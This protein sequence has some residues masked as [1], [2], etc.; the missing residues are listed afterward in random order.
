MSKQS[1]H[2]S[3]EPSALSVSMLVRNLQGQFQHEERKP[4]DLRA[5]L[6][7]DP[8]AN[9][10]AGVASGARRRRGNQGGGKTNAKGIAR[11]GPPRRRRTGLDANFSRA[12]PSTVLGASRPED[13]RMAP[14]PSRPA[15]M[16]ELPPNTAAGCLDRAAADLL[17]AD[18]SIDPHERKQLHQDAK[19]WSRRAEML[20]RVAKSISKRAAL[21]EGSR[22]Y[23][24]D[25]ARHR[26]E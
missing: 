15:T 26:S 17:E 3:D 18:A 19:W 12:R 5:S 4:Q 2:F 10:T 16:T 6:A 23:H 20:Q 14:H 24:R 13:L 21:D 22:Q 25:K 1:F 11:A 7:S 9:G 8:P